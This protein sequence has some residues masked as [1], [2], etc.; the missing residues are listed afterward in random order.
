MPSEC[1][2]TLTYFNFPGRADPLHM[3]AAIG[4]IP[5]VN[6]AIA[7]KDLKSFQAPLRQLPVLEVAYRDENGNKKQFDLYGYVLQQK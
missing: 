2:L 5:F 7:W 6:K 4:K 3:A 1:E